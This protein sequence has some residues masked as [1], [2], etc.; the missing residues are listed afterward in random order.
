MPENKKREIRKAISRM[1]AEELE[2]LWWYLVVEN[3]I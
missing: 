1:T 2:N 3:L